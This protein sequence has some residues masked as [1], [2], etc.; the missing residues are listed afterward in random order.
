MKLVESVVTNFRVAKVFKENTERINS[1]DFSANG[2]TLITSSDDD[3]I[4]IY[5]CEKGT[6]K[7]TLNSKKYGVDLVHY[8]HAANTAIHSSNKIDDTIRYLSLPDNKYI[9]YFP[10][11]TKKVVTLCMSPVDD[12][13]LSGSLDK[14]IRL[15]DLR[16][17]NC[18]GLMHLMG[19]PVANFDPE[20]LIF[21]VGINSESVKLYDLKSFDKGPFNT[22]KLQQDKLCDWTGL[23]F[24][25][26]GKMIMISTNG[27]V[28]HLIDAF[29]GTPLQT[30]MGHVNA[31]N[32]PLE[33]SFSPDS[34]FIFSGSTDG[35]I[36][37]WNASNGNKVTTFQGEHTSTVQCVQFNP[38]YMMLASACTM[39]HFWIPSNCDE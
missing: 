28:I 19:R 32:L 17:P 10:G 16:S 12:T 27:N 14:T 18:Q 1:I 22:F 23:K 21:A 15:W 7:K 25:P 9:R 35:K 36:H 34:Q 2:E 13:F 4:V 29:Q 38:K 26:D 37:V 3:S 24:S 31:K 33:A 11:H 8:T 30:L 6:T 39:M 20:G 5:D